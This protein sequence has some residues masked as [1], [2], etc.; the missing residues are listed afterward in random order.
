MRKVRRAAI[1][2]LGIVLALFVLMYFGQFAYMRTSSA[3]NLAAAKIGEKLGGNVKITELSAGIGSTDLQMEIPGAPGEPALVTGKVSVDVSPL[4]LAIGSEPKIIRIHEPTVNLRLDRDNNI[5]SKL[6]HPPAGGGSGTIPEIVISGAIVHIQQEGKPDFWVKGADLIIASAGAKITLKGSLRDEQY[7]SWKIDGEVESATSSGF[8]HLA[9]DA[10][11]HLTPE[12]LKAIPY[13]PNET[14]EA[15][16][17]DGRT[18]VDVRI[19]SGTSGNW[20]WKV[21]CNPTDTKLIVFPIDLTVT[22]TSASVLVEGSKVT[23]KNVRGT[24]ADGALQTDAILDF[25][26]KPSKLSFRVKAENLDVKK[27]PAEWGLANRVDSGRLNGTAEITLTL[28]EGKTLP[29]GTGV[30]TIVGKFA[31]G[32]AVYEMHL[33]GDGKKLKFVDPPAKSSRRLLT[34]DALAVLLAVLVQPPTETPAKP[35]EKKPEYLQANLKLKDVDIAELIRRGNI[36]AP[37]K[38]AGKVSLE[39]RAEIPTDNLRGIKFYRATGKLSAPKLQIED[40]TLS[41]VSSEIQLKDGVLTLTQLSAAFEPGEAKVRGSILGTAKFGIDPRTEFTSQLTLKSIPLDQVFAALPSL[42][43]KAEGTLSGEF[44]FAVPG[45]KLGDANAVVANG[46]LTS[47]GMTLFGQ[48]LEK[49]ALVLNVRDGVAKLSKAEVA[50][51]QGTITGEA[52]LPLTGKSN[53]TFQFDFKDLN[54][55]AVTK[56]IP[57]SPVK[58]SGKLIGTLGGTLP[59]LNQF[60]AVKLQADLVINSPKLVVQGFPTSKLAGKVGYKPGMITY[61]LKGDALGGSFDIEGNYPLGDKPPEKVGQVPAA[62]FGGTIRIQRLQFERA[63]RELNVAWLENLRGELTLNLKYAKEDGELRGQG[64]LEIRDLGWGDTAE[65]SNILSDVIVTSSG[66]EIP[67]IQGEL[68]GGRLRGSVKYDVDRPAASFA[69]LQLDNAEAATLLTPFGIEC[70]KGRV[71]ATLR[72]KLGKEFRGGGTISMVRSNL[73]G[74]EVSELRIPYRFTKAVGGGAELSIRDARGVVAEGRLVGR[75]EIT[76]NDSARVEGR[77][78]FVDLNVSAFAKSFGGSAL[79]IGK[80]TGRFDFNGAN[81]RTASDL[82]GTLTATLG[83]TSVRELPVLGSITPLMSPVSALTKYDSGNLVARL[84]GGIVRVEEL[85]LSGKGSKLFA[86]GTVNLS[87]TLDLNVVYNT[88]Q[89]GPSAPVIR[90]IARNIP[91]IGPIPVGAIVR[92]TEAISNR[93]IRL[94][95]TGTVNRP[96]ASLNAAG[97]LTEN[98]VR[99]FV[100][101]YAPLPPAK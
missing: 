19:A 86:D 27:T 51:Y 82:K 49:L 53:G 38:L 70:A 7:G 64:R 78:E 61:D 57:E 30:A 24:A 75:T 16:E 34:T 84:G 63:G 44:D 68:A 20:S 101:Q 3:R 18:M 67:R 15:V 54:A 91:A 36:T 17:L 5:L 92:V 14:W 1:L 93:V 37:V 2:I 88:G 80:S 66:L 33:T 10:P 100:G 11:V 94:K 74:I 26:Q 31:G 60:E 23:L 52:K 73:F 42:K 46:K 76:V 6:P 58:L 77:I 62:P 65:S 95:I 85:A 55:D 59:P 41:E 98:A 89:I 21:V 48:T 72:S 45:D 71:S 83:D 22:G 8:V 43:G 50:V 87:G 97:L 96:N 47:A 29:T 99:F 79:G 9:T 35:E 90:T 56:A 32:D 69:T 4:A 39:I 12:K 81:V 28:N 25:G 40:L 13:V